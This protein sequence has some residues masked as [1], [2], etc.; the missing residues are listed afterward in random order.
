ME[1]V[2]CSLKI[3][4]T[5]SPLPFLQVA[6]R[7]GVKDWSNTFGD[8]E[9]FPHVGL[10]VLPPTQRPRQLRQAVVRAGKFLSRNPYYFWIALSFFDH[11]S[12]MLPMEVF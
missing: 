3:I 1:G 8:V 9:V 11:P 5:G 7:L 12:P 4:K 2:K 6:E 10:D